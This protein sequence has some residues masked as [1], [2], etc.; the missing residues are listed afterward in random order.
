MLQS[1]RSLHVEDPL[2]EATCTFESDARALI[3]AQSNSRDRAAWQPSALLPVQRKVPGVLRDRGGL[4]PHERAG[5]NLGAAA[6]HSERS[7]AK[8]G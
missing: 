1:R 6:P 4:Q 3:G 2:R 8:S 5:A 7:C